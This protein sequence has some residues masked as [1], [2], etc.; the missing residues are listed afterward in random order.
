ML[1]MLRDR[2]FK[3]TTSL[4][5]DGVGADHQTESGEEKW[6]E[7]RLEVAHSHCWSRTKL[8]EGELVQG[9]NIRIVWLAF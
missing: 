7:K 2:C 5:R 9:V 1:R 8:Q 6:E 4:C 3:E